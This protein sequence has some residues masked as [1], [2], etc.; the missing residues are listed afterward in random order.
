MSS[1]TDITFPCRFCGIQIRAPLHQAGQPVLC[2]QCKGELFVPVVRH[3]RRPPPVATPPEQQTGVK[4][5]PFCAEQI[6]A[7]AIKC[8]HCGSMLVQGFPQ[9]A[10][11]LRPS[12][13]GVTVPVLISAI[14]NII[15]GLL[16]LSTCFFAFLAIPMAILCIFEF[17]LYAKAEQLHPMELRAKAQNLGVFEI[18]IGLVNTPTLIC[19][20]IVLINSS[21]L[22]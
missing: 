6:A 22:R 7:Q 3:S 8:K 11:M 21:K 1:T 12:I 18:I 13:S 2:P 19:G 20:I 5:C 9:R 16:W 14:S 10:P 15:V 4:I 17:A